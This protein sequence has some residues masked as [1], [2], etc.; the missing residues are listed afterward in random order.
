L[1]RLREIEYATITTDGEEIKEV[2]IVA[3]TARKPKQIVR[4]VESAL[5]AT[6]GRNVDHRVISVVIE[7]EDAAPTNVSRAAPPRPPAEPPVAEAPRPTVSEARRM[8]EPA[9]RYAPRARVAEPTT[10]GARVRFVSANLYVAGLR[11]QA[12][13]ELTWRGMTRLGSA[14]G[15]STRENAERLVASATLSAL[16]PFLG[17]ER[18]LAVEDVARLRMGRRT[19]YVVSVKLLEQ[20]SEKV[21]TGSCTLEQDTPQT[22]VFAT[23]AAVNRILGGL[24]TQEPV[25]YELRPAS[26]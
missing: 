3:R 5:K 4:D 21:L 20:R 26:A 19:V 1:R 18:T 22:V 13:V 11:T 24:S 8:P 25:E 12:Q 14:T 2:H 23:L 7:R 6:L 9:E 17:E 15:P 16:Q 10:G